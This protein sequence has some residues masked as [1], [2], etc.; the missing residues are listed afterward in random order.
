[1]FYVKVTPRSASHKKNYVKNANRNGWRGEIRWNLIYRGKPHAK[2]FVIEQKVMSGICYSI[3]PS[4]NIVYAA[5][6]LLSFIIIS[7][8]INICDRQSNSA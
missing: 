6:Q 5:T 8:S 3:Y 7:S 1:M 4:N 2:G